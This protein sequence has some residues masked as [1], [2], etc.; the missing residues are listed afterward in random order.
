M[1]EIVPIISSSYNSNCYLILDDVKAVV[2]TGIGM[3]DRIIN[4][5]RERTPLEEISLV[6]NTHAHVDH[7]GGNDFFKDAEVLVHFRDAE[8]MTRGRLY[9]TCYLRGKKIPCRVDRKLAE[10]DTLE[11]GKYSLKVLH[12]PGH[13][14]GSI[15]LLDD[16]SKTLFSGDTLFPGGNFGRVDLGGNGEEIIQSLRRLS[17]IDFD[18]LLPGHGGVTKNGKEQARLSYENALAIAKE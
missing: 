1:T 12:T 8:E 9:G 17:A 5:I 13:T 6:I 3:D 16:E 14:P 11:L 2:D 15:C 4:K 18:I 7:C 10:G